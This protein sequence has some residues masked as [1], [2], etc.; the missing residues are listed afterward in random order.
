ML[1]FL[2]CLLILMQ[3][4][5]VLKGSRAQQ[6]VMY[7]ITPAYVDIH[8]QLTLMCKTS[9]R[10]DWRSTSFN[11]E[12]NNDGV[13]S[14]GLFFKAANGSCKISSISFSKY[15]ASCDS[16]KGEY[17]L[18]ILDVHEQYHDRFIRCNVQF[19]DGSGSDVYAN[20]NSTIYVRVHIAEILLSNTT[21]TSDVTRDTS[22]ECK[23]ISRPAASIN[24][25][26]VNSEGA[27]QD[28]SSSSTETV[29]S[30]IRGEM[31][32]SILKF[33]FTAA[34]NGG[35]IYC[36]ADNSIST[37]NSSAIA[38]SI[39]YPPLDVPT[40]QQTPNRPI[41]R[42][43][44]VVLTCSVSGGFPLPVLTW[45]C[46]GNSTNTTSG[47]TAFYTI[48]FM[49]SKQDNGKTC[50]CYATHPV[51][52]YRPQMHV[53]LNVYFPPDEGP[54]LMQKPEGAVNTGHSV[55]LVCSVIGGNPVATLTWNCTGVITINSSETTAMSSIELPITKLNHGMAC[56]CLATHNIDTYKHST[57]HLLVVIFPPEVTPTVR[58]ATAGPIDTETSVKLICS[59]P[60]GSPLAKLTWDCQ[61]I[62][63]NTS[64]ETVAVLEIEFTV[65]K[66][67]NGRICSCSA[68]HPIG[69]YRPTSQYSLV[70][71]FPPSKPNL[72]LKPEMPWFV[73]N[74]TEIECSSVPGNP[75]STFEWTSD[76]MAVDVNI[77]ELII[78]PLTKYNNGK[79]ITCTVQNEYT[80]KHGLILKSDIVHLNVEYFPEIAIDNSPVF[81]NEGDNASI[82]CTALGNPVPLTQ[83]YLQDQNITE[84]QINQ[85][86]LHLFD[87]DR[88][89]NGLVYTCKT[90][91]TSSTY[92]SL[93]AENTTEI[94]VSY[95]PVI[96]NSQVLN[97]WTVYENRAV[98]FRCEV[99]SN[100]VPTIT[101]LFLTNQTKLKT[102]YGVYTSN[103][104]IHNTNCFHTGT[105]QCQAANNISGVTSTYAKDVALNVL[106]SPRLDTRYQAL[107]KIVAVEENGDLQLTARIIAYPSPVIR[108]IFK[109]EINSTSVL[110]GNLYVSNLHIP[111]LKQSEFGEYTLHAFNDH[112]NL[113]EQ[114][115]VVPK[116]K[117]ES[118]SH[119]LVVCKR[120]SVT[121]VWKSEFDGGAKQTFMVTYWRTLDGTTI[122]SALKGNLTEQAVIK[123]LMSDSMYNFI[124]QAT[125]NYGTS[126]SI[127]KTC[128]TDAK[129]ITSK[130]EQNGMSDATIGAVV[131]AVI[132]IFVIILLIS[133]FILI[134]FYRQRKNKDGLQNQNQGYLKP[135]RDVS[136]RSARDNVYHVPSDQQYESIRRDAVVEANVNPTRLIYDE[137]EPE[138]IQ[139]TH[140]SDA[141]SSELQNK[142]QRN[143]DDTS[144]EQRSVYTNQEAPT[145]HSTVQSTSRTDFVHQL[146]T[147]T[148]EDMGTGTKVTQPIKKPPTTRLSDNYIQLYESMKARSCE[149]TSKLDQ[150]REIKDTKSKDSSTQLYESMTTTP[151]E[152]NK[153]TK[154]ESVDMYSSV[155][156]TK[157]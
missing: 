141:S 149:N 140:Y 22:V 13:P 87:V 83:W 76:D 80:I 56:S 4:Y 65:D 3:I 123:E 5:A 109:N 100:P 6:A 147:N 114:V 63:S 118:P 101:W 103:Y 25:I 133:I 96:T 75:E 7:P 150:G 113:F 73:G 111:D 41:I 30:G 48:L 59:V 130:E 14:V 134:P 116:G 31:V 82:T 66:N 139:G 129:D 151:Q 21:I 61:G 157:I 137:P 88:L 153:T 62:T 47:N 79:I 97:G 107:A 78:G 9:V 68:T 154:N 106:C 90:F 8:Q 37:V 95:P 24:W 2:G 85:S 136:V 132:S 142:R 50:T 40:I 70:V 67:Y 27:I 99:D 55:L 42:G 49:A 86:V 23:V 19:G 131:V 32:T 54:V 36:H 43:E 94:I 34:D 126:N 148:Y 155:L 124:V 84:P 122:S 143:Q 39:Y 12:T 1:S 44:T 117:P 115:N 77:S 72:I 108:W 69:T 58:Q 26:K 128:K 28:I 15:S 120:T 144:I 93:V 104:T 20:A 91:A 17:N 152:A 121:I 35:V 127:I 145:D 125:N 74:I 135:V 45:N 51:V 138:N 98:T 60:G 89:L 38:L 105:Y 53:T 110:V 112:G 146:D 92:G 71:Y 10:N 18:T 57:H 81:I 33:R 11:D 16:T 46:S 156:S 119:V 52:E 102:E 64:T 29:N